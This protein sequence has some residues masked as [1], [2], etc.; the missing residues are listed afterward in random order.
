MS[1][2]KFD[3]KSTSPLIVGQL[4][5]RKVKALTGISF[6]HSDVYIYPGAVKHINKRHPLVWNQYKHHLYDMISNPDYIGV[7]PSILNSIELYKVLN[8]TVLLALKLDPSGYVFVSTLYEVNNAAHKIKK[9][10][11]S[12]RVQP[13][14]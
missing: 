1:I 12:G 10:L 8:D 7:N 11:A 5:L 14:V 2:D 9:R 4:D 13:Y 6:S 3:E